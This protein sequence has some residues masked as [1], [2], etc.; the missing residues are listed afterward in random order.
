M[1]VPKPNPN[2][3]EDLRERLQA[4]REARHQACSR[5]KEA[6]AKGRNMTPANGYDT[7]KLA[8]KLSEEEAD[9][10][11]VEGSGIRRLP[12]PQ[13]RLAARRRALEDSR[14]NRTRNLAKL[15][16]TSERAV[17]AAATTHYDPEHLRA[18]IE[19]NGPA[20]SA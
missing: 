14:A 12:C 13:E 18:T 7:K 16:H 1:P 4:A 19:D 3:L 2:S 20:P 5:L 11:D 9:E 10:G 15:K 6:A 17:D 8:D